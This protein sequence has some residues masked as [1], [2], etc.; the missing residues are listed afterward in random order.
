MPYTSPYIPNPFQENYAETRRERLIGWLSYI[1]DNLLDQQRD[2]VS[3]Y[4]AGNI[5]GPPSE[6]YTDLHWITNADILA[7][8][9]DHMCR[10]AA[11]M[12][13]IMDALAGEYDNYFAENEPQLA[14]LIAAAMTVLLDPWYVLLNASVMA[15]LLPEGANPD[16]Y[17]TEDLVL[18]RIHEVIVHFH[19]EYVQLD[20]LIVSALAEWQNVDRLVRHIHNLL[21][22]LTVFSGEA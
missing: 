4:S 3:L 8:K 11:V 20:S 9:R 7:L 13:F 15:D 22:R 6:V 14:I 21:S 10:P 18:D 1:A 2:R 19:A 16:Q 17:S 5:V 12:Q